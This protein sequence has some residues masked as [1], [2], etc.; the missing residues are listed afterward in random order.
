VAG[1]LRPGEGGLDASELARRVGLH[2]NTVRWHLGILADAGLV[3]SAPAV[4]ATRGRPRIL[5]SLEPEPAEQ[6]T[7]EHR[8]LASVLTGAVAASDDGAAR[9]EEAGEAW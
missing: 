6:G 4:R 8:L 2:P 7:D 3:S 9:A 5:Y 1:G